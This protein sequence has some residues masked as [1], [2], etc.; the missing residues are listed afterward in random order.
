MKTSAQVVLINEKGYVLGVSRKNNHSDFGLIGG[1]MD[2]EDNGD[3]MVTA[4]RETKEETGLDITNL[5]LVF[6]IHK[7]GY[8]GYT[9]LADYSGKIDHNEPHVVKWV[10]FET[11]IRGSFGK[12]NQLVSESLDDIGIA[13]IKYLLPKNKYIFATIT[14]Q[15]DDFYNVAISPKKFWDNKKHCPDHYSGVEW[16]DINTLTKNGNITISE[17]VESIFSVTK[18]KKWLKTKE[19]IDKVM[20]EAGFIFDEDFSNF[21]NS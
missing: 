2:P 12:Y 15:D 18:N 10:P 3:P 1:K 13:Y 19:E 11:L 20:T 4:I 5:R 9:Y 8:M 6:A 21:M 16:S 17:E 7:D 14:R